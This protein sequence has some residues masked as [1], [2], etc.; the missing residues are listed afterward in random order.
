MFA[1]DASLDALCAPPD[2]NRFK[3]QMEEASDSIA[4][5]KTFAQAKAQRREADEHELVI[6][7]CGASGSGDFSFDN[8]A[9]AA[10]LG[11]VVE[12]SS[13][14]VDPG[15]KVPVKISYSPPAGGPLSLWNEI[16]LQATLRGGTP[17]AASGAVNVALRLRGFVPAQL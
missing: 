8:A 13:G 4:L 6:G 15:G 5:E 10:A 7:N 14:K 1:F 2:V 9:D 16:V 12:P 3:D 17:V 11:F